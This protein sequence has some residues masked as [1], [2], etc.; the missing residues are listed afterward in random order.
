[1]YSAHVF[2]KEA[3]RRI[4]QHN[5]LQRLFLYLAYQSVHSPTQVP[6]EYVAPYS[7]LP[8]PRRTFAGMLAALDEGV[9]N[10]TAALKAASLYEDSVIW[11]QTDN[12][13]PTPSCGGAQGGQNWPLR[14]GKEEM[15]DPPSPSLP[16]PFL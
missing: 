15:D 13:A 8:E 9:G 1:M 2:T 11:F 3:V 16:R 6:D 7:A 4:E 5:T 12:G 14:G 10:V